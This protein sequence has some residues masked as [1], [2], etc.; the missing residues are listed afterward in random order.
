MKKPGSAMQRQ[1]HGSA[2][3]SQESGLP[4]SVPTFGAMERPG[5]KSI[6]LKT[7]QEIK[8]AINHA[9]IALISSP[10]YSLGWVRSQIEFEFRPV[11]ERIVQQ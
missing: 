8:Q 2:W 5:D 9:T 1:L 11:S 10:D 6:A 3:L 4:Q 7:D